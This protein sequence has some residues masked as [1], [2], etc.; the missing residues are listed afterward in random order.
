MYYF[1]CLL[2]LFHSNFYNTGMSCNPTCTS[3]PALISYLCF[4]AFNG[5]LAASR[6][7]FSSVTL[8]RPFSLIA[9]S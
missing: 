2:L 4:Y 1:I 7:N 9:F 6:L 8:R 5:A 3:S